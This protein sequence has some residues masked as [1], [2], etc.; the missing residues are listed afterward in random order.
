MLRAMAA[1]GG[2][3]NISGVGSGT[4]MTDIE[5]RSS[6]Q[7]DRAQLEALYPQAFPEE[8]LLPVLGRLG[9]SKN[10]PILAVS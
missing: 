2:V 5:I 7:A 9:T 4:G 6:R 8:N 1:S 10:L 3:A